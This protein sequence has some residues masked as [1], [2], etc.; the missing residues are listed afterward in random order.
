MPLAARLHQFGTPAESI[1]V[2]EFPARPPA[3]GEVVVEMLAAPINP[4]DINVIEGKYGDLPPLPATIGNE[5]VGRIA[6][7]GSDVTG[8]SIGQTVLPMSFGTW[9]REM[10]IP[11]ASIVP[12]PD[13]LDIHQAA[14][15]TV[16]PATAW[17]LLHDFV[18]LAPGDWI[19]QNAANSGVGRSVIQLARA[20]GLRTVNVVR[21]PEL[22]EELLASGADHVVTEECDLRTEISSLCGG[23]RPKLGLNAVGGSSALN[24]ANALARGGCVVTFGAMS[25]QPLKIPN[26]LL[27]FS[28]IRFHGFWLKRWRENATRTDVQETYG[29]LAAFLAKGILN[30]PV[31]GVFP[32]ADLGNALAAAAKDRRAGKTLLDLAA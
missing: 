9:T 22:I 28:D 24:V 20:L 15:L 25:K 11:S 7:L 19:V 27:I 2:A 5:G 17:R 32:L 31:D 12:L 4:A 8:L 23:D 21:R 26:G 16:N 14:M 3:P 6:A 30:T 13:G 10:T 1:S 29:S 18:A